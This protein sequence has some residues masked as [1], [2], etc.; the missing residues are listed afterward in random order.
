VTGA[1]AF[2]DP[3]GPP[4]VTGGLAIIAGIALSSIPLLAGNRRRPRPCAA[5]PAGSARRPARPVGKSR[6]AAQAPVGATRTSAA[7]CPDRPP[8]ASTGSRRHGA[9]GG[10]RRAGHHRVR[11]CKITGH[12]SR[13][14]IQR[15]LH[16]D[17]PPPAEAGTA[18]SEPLP[19]GGLNVAPGGASFGTWAESQ[20][21]RQRDQRC[22]RA[23]GFAPA[24]LD[25]HHKGACV[26]AG[27]EHSASRNPRA[28]HASCR[29]LG[30]RVSSP[31]LLIVRG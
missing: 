5:P 24:T 30:P 27:R 21:R 13:T 1:V 20:A 16:P 26:L 7:R 8:R 4:Q 11:L 29:W 2:A 3:V 23:A 25:P 10:T 19:R 17:H 15:H 12:G 9:R 14:A 28:C 22:A 18:G 6:P 31:A